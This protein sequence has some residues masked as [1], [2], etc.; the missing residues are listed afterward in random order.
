[1]VGLVLLVGFL[2]CAPVMIE[3]A[4]HDIFNPVYRGFLDSTRRDAWQ[5][6][7]RVIDSLSIRSGLVV[8]DIGAGTG[9]F[10]WR[11]AERVGSAGLVY[12]TDVH[13][14]MIDDLQRLVEDRRL[15][16][17]E[18]VHAD[19]DDSRLPVA[20]CDLI[21][22]A[23]VY[24]EIDDRVRYMRKVA[25]SLKPTGRIAIVGFSPEAFGLGPPRH[26]RLSAL[27]VIEELTQAGFTLTERHEFLP[28]QYF[29]VFRL[30]EAS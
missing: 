25:R 3:R 10:T 21:F 6:P 11:F 4:G 8:A 19:F 23:N 17:V 13:E 22:L 27:Q 9:Y 28:R 26:V 1:M 15:Q 29:L 18:V 14:V 12:A 20:C 30:S 5:Q 16:N 2:G 24:K 7:N